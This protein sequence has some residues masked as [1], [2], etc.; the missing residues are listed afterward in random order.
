MELYVNNYPNYEIHYWK[1]Y[2]LEK[3]LKPWKLKLLKSNS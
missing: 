2:F 3:D 1:L